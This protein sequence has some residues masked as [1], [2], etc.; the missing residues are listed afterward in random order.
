MTQEINYNNVQSFLDC[1]SETSESTVNETLNGIVDTWKSLNFKKGSAVLLLF[2][3]CRDFL[4]NIFAISLAGYVPALVPP[5]TPINRIN[6]IAKQFNAK[7]IIKPKLSPNSIDNVIR[8]EKINNNDVVILDNNDQ[9]LT[10]AGELIL[11]TSG[12]SGFNSGCVF[13]FAALLR[14]ADKHA[15]AINIKSNDIILVSLPLYYSYAFVAQALSAFQRN[16]KLVISSPPFGYKK[17]LSDIERQNITVSSLTPLLLKELLTHELNLPDCLRAITVGGDYLDPVYTKKFIERYPTKE[18]YLTYGITEAGPRVATLAAHAESPDKFLSVGRPLPNTDTF[19]ME[20]SN[21]L[22]IHSDTLVK[23]RLGAPDKPLFTT[24]DNKKWLRTGDIFTIDS[25]GYLYFKRRIS[26]FVIIKGEK[27]NLADIKKLAIQQ[28]GVI[29]AKIDLINH[30]S[31]LTGFNLDIL[32]HEGFNKSLPEVRD[33]VF[34]KLKLYERPQ[35][36]FVSRLG[37][38]NT[39]RYK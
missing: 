25:N 26:D 27:I 37:E 11:T 29:S 10:S 34:K 3:N 19:L 8:I 38:S 24:K 22:L 1:I 36:V 9:D 2:P 15:D 4:L 30:Q 28:P 17:Y 33:S 23:N 6:L 35:N 7:A 14:N 21:E 31:E 13:D 16:A 39:E 18:L 5:A 32:V 12:T 20:D